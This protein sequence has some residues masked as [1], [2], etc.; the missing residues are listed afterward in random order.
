MMLTIITVNV[1]LNADPDGADASDAV[2]GIDDY[3]DVCA[4]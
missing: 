1:D 3:A 4:R 2:A